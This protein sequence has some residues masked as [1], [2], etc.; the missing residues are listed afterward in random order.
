LNPVL[1]EF[2]EAVRKKLAQDPERKFLIEYQ[3][4]LVKSL[5][6]SWWAT[7]RRAGIERRIR[8]YDFRHY[9][10]TAL[11]SKGADIK[12]ASK[13]LGHSSPATTLKVYYH[14]REH[15]KRDAVRRLKLPDLA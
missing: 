14:L 10:A 1:P 15:Q 5:K 2:L 4:R 11:L 3:G 6:T 9:F 13:L 8:L 12:A 7:L